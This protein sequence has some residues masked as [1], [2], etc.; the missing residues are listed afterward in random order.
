VLG[1]IGN[2][3]LVF[4]CS[5]CL[6]NFPAKEFVVL[7]CGGGLKGYYLFGASI[8]LKDMIKNSQIN[9]SKYVGVSIGA[10]AIVF[11]ISSL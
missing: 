11:L 6:L 5:A 2:T 10:L 7:M 3:I 1:T 8:F 4:R 9:I